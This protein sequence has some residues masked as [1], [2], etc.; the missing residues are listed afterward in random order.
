MRNGSNCC[1]P[2][3]W[4]PRQW[5]RSD[6]QSARGVLGREFEQLVNEFLPVFEG[7]SGRGGWTVPW[8][9]VE[10]NSGFEMMLD[11]PGVAPEDVQVEF[12]D[13]VLTV[14]GQRSAPEQGEGRQVHRNERR[15]GSFNRSI[16]LPDAD[17]ER[18]SAEF[19]HGVLVV[20]APKLPAATSR[21]IEV[22]LG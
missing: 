11:L 4:S 19:K 2:R 9:I 12:N 17:G 21:K 1:G 14:S 18:I 8:D 7:A 16:K 10:T 20:V 3:Q 5:S 13:G 6:A 15:W 22:K